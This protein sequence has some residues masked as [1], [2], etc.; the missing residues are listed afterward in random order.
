MNNDRIGAKVSRRELL[1]WSGLLP[2][3]QWL[4][5]PP[6]AQEKE[7]IMQ[8]P[9]NIYDCLIVGG[10]SAGL[11]A[12]L[13]LGRARRR[14]LVCD[15]G[16]P[17]NAPAPESHGF[18]TRDGVSPLE[19]LNIARDQLRPYRTVQ[20]QTLGVREILKTSAGFEAAFEDGSRK[21]ARK[22]LLAFGV[23]DEFPAIENFGD[24]WGK[25]VF[26]CP[27][28][29]GFEVRDQPLAVVGNGAAAIGMAALLKNWSADLVLCTN[30]PAELSADQR[31]LLKNQKVA[32]REEKIV[33]LE[34]QNGHL[35]NIVF[36]TGQKLARGGM[37]IR[38]KQKLRSDLAEKLGCELN[39]MGFI[40]TT[41]LNETTVQGVYAA[42]DVTSPMQSLAVAVS[43]GAVA[44]GGGINHALS[45][46]DFA[47]FDSKATP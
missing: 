46:E 16:N 29:H 8:H 19:L 36:E 35:E 12:A 27:Y 38:P 20:F 42:G 41:A 34:G 23:K 47:A 2:L 6:A 11:S 25:S 15:K 26:Y 43:Q 32:L 18:L 22:I 14:V 10:G 9:K 28:C 7:K 39:E 5:T 45:E 31:T 30:G 13:T 37:L 17:R 33:R 1:I 4:Q 40:K 24:F 44:A 3:G 21:R